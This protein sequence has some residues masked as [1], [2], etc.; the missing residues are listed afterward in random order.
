MGPAASL[1]PGRWSSPSGPSPSTEQG[2][3]GAAVRE[4]GWMYI[5]QPDSILKTALFGKNGRDRI[6]YM[7]M[8]IIYIH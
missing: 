7:H 6:L 3:G 1:L 8:Y 2:K 5:K 4:T